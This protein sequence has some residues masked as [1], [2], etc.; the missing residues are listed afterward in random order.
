MEAAEPKVRTYGNWRKPTSPGIGQLGLIGTGL[1]L[2]SL[3]VVIVTVGLFGLVV[4]I[5]VGAILMLMLATLVFRDKHG[6]T[7]LQRLSTWIVWRRARAGGAHLYR[8]GPLGRSP[9]GTFQL[10]GLAARSTLSE[11]RDSYQRPFALLHMPTTGHYTVVFGT[12]PDG[13][14]LVDQE[15][16]DVWVAHWGSWLASLAD[17]PGVVAGV[18]ITA[19]CG[20]RMV[21]VTAPVPDPPGHQPTQPGGH[22]QQ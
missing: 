8:S 12:E 4:A 19:V 7:V 16:I 11:A 14:S 22:Q 5:V 1:L 3:I 9:W 10:P 17:E 13:A 20:T 6:R 18:G 2:G 21:V 15:Q